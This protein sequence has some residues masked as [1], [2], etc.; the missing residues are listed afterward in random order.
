MKKKRQITFLVCLFFFFNCFTVSRKTKKDLENCETIYKRVL[1]SKFT[2]EHKQSEDVTLILTSMEE[3]IPPKDCGDDL[4]PKVWNHLALS[5]DKLVDLSPYV[6]TD[7][8]KEHSHIYKNITVPHLLISKGNNFEPNDFVPNG[9][10]TIFYF[11]AEWCSMCKVVKP[12]LLKYIRIKEKV[13]IREVDVLDWE[14]EAGDK[15]NQIARENGKYKRFLP[16]IIVF[17]NG[18]IFYLGN[19]KDYIN[20][21]Y[22]TIF[23]AITHPL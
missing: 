16:Y 11:T 17:E 21:E 15:L 8:I 3:I 6:V 18:K 19:V 13:L 7:F 2:L 14:S 20:R 9:Y 12:V 5:I 1:G 4:P 10:K 22:N 23:G